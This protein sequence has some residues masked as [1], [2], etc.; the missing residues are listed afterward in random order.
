MTSMRRNAEYLAIAQRASLMDRFWSGVSL[1]GQDDCW[2][3]VRSGDC[4][5]YGRF[6]HNGKSFRAHRVA[7]LA[8]AP[9]TPDGLVI[10]H[11]CRNRACVNPAHLRA[12]TELE[13]N[14]ASHSLT[15]GAINMR[16]THC[17]HGHEFTPE[18]IYIRYTKGVPARFC[19]ECGRT[20]VRLRRQA[21][22]EQRR[23]RAILS[24]A[25]KLKGAD[26][27]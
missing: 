12:V 23:L 26:H 4:N 13:N 14:L 10:D 22:R 24:R 11:L 17:V 18:N 27:G 5:G 7:Y 9:D 1:S 8:Q 19:R 16:K 6:Y 3:Y 25:G 15:F 20:R 21:A 2:E